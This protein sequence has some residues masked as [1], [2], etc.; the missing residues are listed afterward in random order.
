MRNQGEYAKA[1]DQL[2]EMHAAGKI[3]NNEYTLKRAALIKEA[4]QPGRPIAWRIIGWVTGGIIVL[5]VLAL[6]I[7]AVINAATS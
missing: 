3:G 2:D 1:L 6:V 4:G 7:Q 5:L